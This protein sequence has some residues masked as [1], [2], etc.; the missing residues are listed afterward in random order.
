MPGTKEPFAKRQQGQKTSQQQNDGLR[1]GSSNEIWRDK[2]HRVRF[3]VPAG[4]ARS[5]W[6]IHVKGNETAVRDAFAIGLAI[7]AGTK[8]REKCVDH[9][10]ASRARPRNADGA[11]LK[12]CEAVASEQT[13]AGWG[14]KTHVEARPSDSRIILNDKVAAAGVVELQTERTTGHYACDRNTGDTSGGI[15]KDDRRIDRSGV[16]SARRQDQDKADCESP[17]RFHYYPLV[18]TEQTFK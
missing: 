3:P 16:S 9:V 11:I 12:E 17:E 6:S 10:R 7:L 2:G 13:R 18:S 4:R 5:T 1:L 8:T 15:A 14:K